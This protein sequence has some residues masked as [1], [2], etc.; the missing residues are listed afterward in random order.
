MRK[1]GVSSDFIKKRDSELL[2]LWNM[3]RQYAYEDKDKL[4]K[5]QD[6][7]ELV[8]TLPC[9]GFFISEDSALRYI[10][11]R[12]NGKTPHLKSRHKRILYERLYDIVMS[13]RIRASYVPMDTKKLMCKAMMMRAPCIGLSPARIRSEIERLTKQ[14]QHEQDRER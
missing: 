3:A 13:L 6:L 8:S 5:V 11:A 2:R 7:Y 9:N 12:R 10:C 4:Y 1:R 14:T